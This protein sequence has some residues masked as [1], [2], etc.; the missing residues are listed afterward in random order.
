MTSLVMKGSGSAPSSVS[1][2]SPQSHHSSPLTSIVDASTH[3]I[4]PQNLPN[5][6]WQYHASHMQ[7]NSTSSL[8]L[9]MEVYPDLF[10]STVVSVGM[11][12]G[13]NRA[14]NVL[15]D[16]LR[17]VYEHQS[18]LSPDI[19]LPSHLHQSGSYG[20]SSGM[21]TGHLP[22]AHSY[23]T[24]FGSNLFG[25]HSLFSGH[26]SLSHPS[27]IQCMPQNPQESWQNFEAQYKP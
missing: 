20:I 16:D 15:S 17:L 18:H 21:G 22:P 3:Y 24:L 4:S 14:G 6:T 26:G 23:E 10:S 5:S 7:P 8:D 9:P 2:P 12:Q 1:E 25:Q 13:A 27:N 11:V 19:Q